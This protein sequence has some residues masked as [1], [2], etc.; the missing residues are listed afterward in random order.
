M[1]CTLHPIVIYLLDN[2]G[3][4]IND[5]LCFISDDNTHDTAFVYEVQTMMTEYVKAK[6]PHIKGL[7]YFSDGFAD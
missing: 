5:S 4:I 2:K 1:Y 7:H 3:S 6:Y